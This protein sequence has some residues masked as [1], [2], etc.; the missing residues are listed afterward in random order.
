MNFIDSRAAIEIA[1]LDRIDLLRHH[2]AS[3]Q[4]KIPR[5]RH[6]TARRSMDFSIG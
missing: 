3:A 1:S 4:S 5:H 2:C 6:M